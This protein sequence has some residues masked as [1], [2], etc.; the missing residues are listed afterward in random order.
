MVVKMMMVVILMMMMTMQLV[1]GGRGREDGTKSLFIL[2][3]FSAGI[4][5]H[6]AEYQTIMMIIIIIM[7]ATMMMMMMLLRL[8]IMIQMFMFL[9]I[10]ITMKIKRISSHHILMHASKRVLHKRIFWTLP[11]SVRTLNYQLTFV[12]VQCVKG[13]ENT[14]SDE[15]MFIKKF[16][17]WLILSPSFTFHQCTAQHQPVFF[18]SIPI[19][20]KQ[21]NLRLKR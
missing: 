2:A 17:G 20:I 7:M 4:S 1:Q 19:N 13:D 3:H 18:L 9:G 16:I 5:I 11:I 6:T 14:T 15:K 8:I 21:S 12:S 10:S